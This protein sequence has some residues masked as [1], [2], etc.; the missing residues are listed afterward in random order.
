MSF[1][2]ARHKAGFS[3]QQVA[4][5]LKISDVA[6]YYWETG[7]QAPRASRLP[8]IAALY[9][10]RYQTFRSLYPALK[11]LFPQMNE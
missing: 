6:V 1:R 2:S 8:E 5:A 10:K 3:V 11:N 4:D 9:E 7:Q